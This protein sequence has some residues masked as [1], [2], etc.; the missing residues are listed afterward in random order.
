MFSKTKKTILSVRGERSGHGPRTFR[1]VISPGVITLGVAFLLGATYCVGN[2]GPGNSGDP[3]SSDPNCDQGIDMTAGGPGQL[4]T[5]IFPNG[6]SDVQPVEDVDQDNGLISLLYPGLDTTT[7]EFYPDL[8]C[9]PSIGGDPPP[10]VPAPTA[11]E[12]EA[13]DFLADYED[14]YGKTLVTNL[15]LNP[16]PAVGQIPNLP[17]NTGC[18]ITTTQMSFIKGAPPTQVTTNVECDD[19]G[20]LQSGQPF[21]GRD[22]IYVHGLAFEHLTARISAL[23]NGY[24][25][26]SLR[27]WPADSSEFLNASTYYRNFAEDYWA[28]HIQEHLFDPVNPANPNGGWQWTSSDSSPVYIPKSNRYLI[29]AWSSN[30]TLEYAMHAFLD[31][32]QR[33]IAYNTNVITPPTSPMSP[34]FT[35]SP[36][37]V[38]PFCSNGC[39]VITHSTAGLIV[40]AALSLANTGFYGTGGQQIVNK[41]RVHVSLAG[42]QSGSRLATVAL[43]AANAVSV[44][45]AVPSLICQ[46]LN[47]LLN[48]PNATAFPLA[49]VNNSILRDLI[50]AVSQGVWGPVV[51][52]SPVKTVAIPGSHPT[53][54]YVATGM[55]LPGLDDGVVTMNSACGNP[56]NVQPGLLAPS[57]FI[58]TSQIKAF[59]MGL[60]FPRAAK[61]WYNAH[62]RLALTPV[63]YLAGPCTPYLD[64]TGMVMPVLLSMSGSPLYDSRKRYNNHFSFVQSGAEHSYNGSNGGSGNSS[65][66]FPST[67]SAP[68]GNIREYR[69]YIGVAS[70]EETSAVTN[71]A[72]Y[73]QFADGS[74]LVH[75]SFGYQTREIVRGRKIAFKIFGNWVSRWIW[76]RTYHVL[77]KWE[78]KQSANFAYEFVSRH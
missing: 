58:P 68:A 17:P 47:D 72:I 53:G 56:L 24:D 62:N 67:Q 10:T 30:Q 7:D 70:Q 12:T 34:S 61:L 57:G 9:D 8:P 1:T 71:A 18:T 32:V 35:G 60:P 77:D 14:N 46:A 52:A 16:L 75:P 31:Q 15:T 25:H 51:E 23:A 55:L 41:I 69:T 5:P 39:I 74:Y 6:T 22:I 43:A 20:F 40:P 37:M 21:E 50:P 4:P 33:A 2:G 45:M 48:L 65:N 42:A 63:G 49:F 64:A 3:G 28:P 66:P 73:Q 19:P 78:H 59:N 26:G 36:A 54:T 27:N 11:D 38:R 29:V 44:A 76:K 13:E